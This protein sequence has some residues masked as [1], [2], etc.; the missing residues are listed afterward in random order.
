MFCFAPFATSL[1]P[2]ASAI[3]TRN[4]TNMSRTDSRFA[5]SQRETSLQCNDVS[6]WLGA[7][8]ESAPMSLCLPS[9][10]VEW[11][12]PPIAIQPAPDLQLL[13]L[14]GANITLPCR[15]VFGPDYETERRPANLTWR[16]DT[17]APDGIVTSSST[18][19]AG[20]DNGTEDGRINISFRY[21][22]W[23]RGS[24]VYNPVGQLLSEE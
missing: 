13:R 17:L 8:L 6:R 4:Y 16:R 19:V 1:T 2:L 15:G 5:P 12:E 21:R 23:C 14:P 10:C 9:D 24:L 22:L 7:N 20:V 11:D 3:L 18:W